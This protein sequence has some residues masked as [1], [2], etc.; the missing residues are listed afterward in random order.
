M[1]L[2]KGKWTVSQVCLKVL[3]TQFI[4][5][6]FEQAEEERYANKV[7]EYFNGGVLKLD[8]HERGITLRAYLAQK[9][10]CDPMRITKKYTG[11]SCLGKRVYHAFKQGGKSEE[12]DRATADLN[13]LEDDFR[14][15]LQ[16]MNKRRGGTYTETIVSTPGIESM[17]NQAGYPA[18]GWNAQ[19]G[20]MYGYP[21][22]GY[23]AVDMHIKQQRRR[24]HQYQ[25]ASGH[26]NGGQSSGANCPMQPLALSLTPLPFNQILRQPKQARTHRRLSS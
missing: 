18:A 22:P 10:G 4:S 9:L 19:P 12:I 14:S 1:Y 20:T 26:Q 24:Q 3:M 15:R 17:L 21:V 13:A 16:Q 8:D 2:R 11:A 25:H 23:N 5:H 7:I 6:I